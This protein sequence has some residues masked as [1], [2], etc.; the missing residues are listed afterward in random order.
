MS[1]QDVGDDLLR[2]ARV[3]DVATTAWSTG[4]ERPSS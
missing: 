1:P 3:V 2:A 4:L